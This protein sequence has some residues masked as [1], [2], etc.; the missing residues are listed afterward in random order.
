[1]PMRDWRRLRRM[2]ES[3]YRRTFQGR[4][5][6]MRHQSTVYTAAI[7]IAVIGVVSLPSPVFADPGSPYF[8]ESMLEQQ[9]SDQRA[10]QPGGAW[11]NARVNV[12][13]YTSAATDSALGVPDPALGAV[14]AGTGV[15]P[16][17][18]VPGLGAVGTATSAALTAQSAAIGGATAGGVGGASTGAVGA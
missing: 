6:A 8:S 17:G 15:M 12:P 18:A 14:T 13:K 9:L 1:M 7:A 4:T 10:A 16:G 11:N 5:I 3:A 2:V